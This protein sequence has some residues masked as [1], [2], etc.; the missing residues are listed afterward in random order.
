MG[1]SL[2]WDFGG[3]WEEVP[4]PT[5]LLRCAEVWC[6]DAER[7]SQFARESRG[8]VLPV[9]SGLPGRVWQ[10]GEPAWITDVRNDEN[11][12]R[13]TYFGRIQFFSVAEL[14]SYERRCAAS[15]P[16]KHRRAPRCE[17][18]EA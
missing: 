17:R 7:L 1:T 6:D 9:G 4:G 12:P 14:E 10:S 3:L 15:P 13:A 16:P 11:F 8:T 5:V 18:T 2:D